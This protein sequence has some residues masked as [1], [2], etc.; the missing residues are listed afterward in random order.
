MEPSQQACIVTNTEIAITQWNIIGFEH[1]QDYSNNA[2][3]ELQEIDGFGSD[4]I[5]WDLVMPGSASVQVV[6][7][8]AVYTSISLYDVVWKPWHYCINVNVCGCF[9][10]ELE[11]DVKSWSGSLCKSH[12]T[13]AFCSHF[14][15]A[16][17]I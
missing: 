11:P 1:I 5:I 4:A 12:S 3:Q 13:M 6:T 17:V 14:G 8:E 9:D 10:E 15:G 2:C 7:A 16:E